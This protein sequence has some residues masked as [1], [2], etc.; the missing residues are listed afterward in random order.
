MVQGSGSNLIQPVLD[1]QL[2]ASSPLLVPEEVSQLLGSQLPQ[3]ATALFA[4]LEAKLH[5]MHVCKTSS[6]ISWLMCL[7][8]EL[9]ELTATR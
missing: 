3:V 9:D 6:K 1:N 7:G 8:T 4:L 2:K 5:Q